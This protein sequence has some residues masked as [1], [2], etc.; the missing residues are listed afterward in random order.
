MNDLSVL[1]MAA[2]KGTRMVS[3]RAKVLHTL[4]GKPMLRLVYDAAA[5]LQP[6]EI[7][8]IVGQD[9]EQVRS[10]LEGLP[11]TF[12]LQAEQRGTGHAVAAARDVLSRKEGDL[13]VLFGDAPRIRTSTLEKLVQQH[14]RVGADLT[15][16]TVHAPNPFAYGR[17]LRDEAGGILAIVEEKD[18]SPMQRMI[19]EV[20]P[21]FYCFRIPPLLESLDNLRDDNAQKEYY[22]TDL[23]GIQRCAGRRIETLLHSDFEE[24]RG[25]NTRQELA[26][27]AGALRAEKN[28]TLMA[29]GV[30]L[31][32][33]DLTFVDLDVVVQKDVTL[34]PMVTLEGTT[35]VREGTTIRAGTRVVNSL[36]GAG[37][38]ILD[39]CLIVDST[40]GDRATIGPFAHLRQGTTVAS[41]CRV[42][43][44]V[45]VKKGSLGEG[46]KAAHLAYLGDAN[47][48]KNV[49]IGAG[50][51]T[52]NYDGVQKHVT[53]IEEGAFIGT[54]SQLVAPVRIGKGAYVAA[55][56]CI[57][58]D[59]PPES[60]AIARS[61]Q[62]VK[63][64]WAR[65][66]KGRN[67][68]HD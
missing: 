30:T 65:K 49:N 61:R 57:T 45:E 2:G 3:E 55:G 58:E 13:L 34:Y 16:L 40:I 12:V 36:I 33:P 60:L 7:F 39:S 41:R 21:G 44:F 20:N 22:V 67:R 64:G 35:V 8:T 46:T 56:S 48:G 47:I 68:Q 50:T 59:V 5:A 63:R 18:A 4:C 14:R 9:A 29:A 1:I 66:R 6:G 17:I 62:E 10:A 51:I 37:V 32:D 26:E 24:L 31:V 11:V 52:C 42:G 23:I 19:T 15:L 25:I 38:E 27:L 28:N 54:D 43:N 53:V